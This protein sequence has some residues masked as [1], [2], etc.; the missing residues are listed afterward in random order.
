MPRSTQQLN[1]FNSGEVTPAL[2]GR[3]D[4]EQYPYFV[5][6]LENMFVEK[7]GGVKSRGGLQYVND[8]R[9]SKVRLVPFVFSREQ[10]YVLEFGDRYIRFFR[11]Q[12]YVENAGD[13]Q[14]YL[15]DGN[16]DTFQYPYGMEQETFAGDGVETT[17]TYTFDVSGDFVV[18]LYTGGA[19]VEQTVLNAPATPGAGQVEHDATAKTVRFPTAPADGEY[20]IIADVSI[21]PDQ[22][23]VYFNGEL[24]ADTEYTITPINT[25]KSVLENFTNAEWDTDATNI[26]TSWTINDGLNEA[27][28][29]QG[30]EPVL[31]EIDISLTHGARIDWGVVAQTWTFTQNTINYLMPSQINLGEAYTEIVFITADQDYAEVSNNFA[32]RFQ[33]QSPNT[34]DVVTA[35]FQRGSTELGWT[36]IVEFNE[37]VDSGGT[38]FNRTGVISNNVVAGEQFRIVARQ[39][40]DASAD[41]I[42]PFGIGSYID[43]DFTVNPDAR[44]RVRARDSQTGSNTGSLD[45]TGLTAPY[46]WIIGNDIQV[47]DPQP[48]LVEFYTDPGLE[49]TLKN[50]YGRNSRPGY[51]IKFNTTP[52]NGSTIILRAVPP[53]LTEGIFSTKK[54]LNHENAAVQAIGDPFEIQSPF[55]EDDLDDL[56]WAQANDV[57]MICHYRYAP[58]RLERTDPFNWQ[59]TQPT[60]HGAVW[61]VP[62]TSHSA[63]G[64]D[65][66]EP[67]VK[68]FPFYFSC[69][70]KADMEVYFN[71]ELQAASGWNLKTGQTF[72]VDKEGDI[73]FTTAPPLG[74]V[75][76]ISKKK[77]DIYNANGNGVRTVF[78]Y[79]FTVGSASELLVYV[80]GDKQSLTTDYTVNTGASEVTFVVPPPDGY[81]VQIRTARS[82][83][84][85]AHGYPRCVVWF[86]ERLVFAA[87]VKLPQTMWM[88]RSADF[89]D[90]YVPDTG[91][92][93][94]L[95]PDAALEYT[96]ASYTHESIEWLSSERVLVIGTAS[97]EHRLAPDTYLASDRLPQVSKMTNYGGAHQMPMYMGNMTCFIQQSGHQLRSF[98]QRTDAVVEDYESIDLSWMNSHMVE[99][100]WIKEPYYSLIP[101]NVAVMVREDG[102]MLAAMYDPSN[103][104]MKAQDMGWSRLITD[105]KIVSCCVIPTDFANEIWVAVE[106][107]IQGQTRLFIEYFRNDH[108]LDSALFTAPGSPPTDT[109]TGLDHLEGKTVYILVDGAVHPEQVVVNGSVSL[110]WEGVDIVIGLKYSRK[111]E[112][113]PFPGGNDVGTGFGKPGRWNEIWVQLVESANPIINGKRPSVRYPSTKMNLPQAPLTGSVRAFDT[114]YRRDKIITVE[115]DLPLPLHLVSIYGTFEVHSG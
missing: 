50:I 31:R 11:D 26:G 25:L 17:F 83:Y 19:W 63:K 58:Y 67:L 86:Q 38:D 102:Q 47:D 46:S 81:A 96:M 65:E 36:T 56:Y 77:D 68:E 89:Y 4:T 10:S 42:V 107:E 7:H 70:A 29:P 84:N 9:G 41:I 103:G 34:S 98:Q 110:E 114:G 76:R 57:M 75:V 78:D 105:G 33:A 80:G 28:S 111:V 72:P 44:L 15:G 87:T 82:D 35:E 39:A 61:D 88:S 49:I 54:M 115:K 71:G 6:T 69:A 97:T 92:G 5:K 95:T 22:I 100:Y 51:E 40:N 64:K 94:T 30:S 90:F 112:T 13:V 113:M 73:V 66:A 24:L 104:T 8:A 99:T 2:G 12:G 32:V 43:G 53:E 91:K 79:G 93:Q 109:I 106:R 55:T 74:T 85:P 16:T 45:L 62:A 37:T 52:P 20:V 59:L 23:E 1:A 18:W 48:I 3:S 14:T 60:F 21:E 108:W 101:N 27:T